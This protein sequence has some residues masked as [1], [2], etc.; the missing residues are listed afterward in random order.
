MP[1]NKIR[2]QKDGWQYID[3]QVYKN[4]KVV[5]T[6]KRHQKGMMFDIEANKAAIKDLSPNAFMLYSHFIQNTPGYIE[7]LSKKRLIETTALTEKTYYRAVSELIDKNYLVPAEHPD[8]EDF[9]IFYELPS[10]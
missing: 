3:I 9:Y 2:V 5:Q 7:A 10:S 1:K 8:Y 6:I 4:Q